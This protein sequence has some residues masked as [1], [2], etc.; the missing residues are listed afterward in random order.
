LLN[1][2]YTTFAVAALA[3]TGL[4]A[5]R[6]AAAQTVITG[7]FD[8]GVNSAGMSLSDGTLNDPHYTLTSVP[9]G[10]T[11]VTRVRTSA[12]G[13]PIPPYLGDSSTSA[14]I[15]PNNGTFN[16]DLAGP[17][18]N[19][20]YTTT[21][22][23]LGITG[24]TGSAVITGN[25]AT[26]NAG[27]DI[28]INGVSTGNKNTNGF[29]TYTPFTLNATNLKNGLNTLTFVVFNQPLPGTNLNTAD[30]PTALRVDGINASPAPEPSQFAVLGFAVLGLSG[31]ILKARKRQAAIAAAA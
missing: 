14:W 5:A 4:A 9:P 19:Y 12:G 25:W 28:L 16:N 1:A 20:D 29:T 27:T 3:L 30:N 10:S 6:P 8:T 22:T 18:G 24:A 2:R 11:T 7:L 26:D 15:G 17:D 31:L 21:F 23:A 13:Y